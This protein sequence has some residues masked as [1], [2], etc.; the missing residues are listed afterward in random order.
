MVSLPAAQPHAPY[1]SVAIPDVPHILQEP[2]FC[3][4]ACLAMYLQKLGRR[5]AQDDVFNSSGLDPMLAR[6]CYTRDLVRAAENL[7]FRPGAIYYRIS[8]DHAAA[9]VEAQWKALHADLL[10]GIPSV[11]CMH[12]DEGPGAPEHFRLVLGY[13]AASDTVIFH[14]PAVADGSYKRMPRSTL[15]ALW[16]LSGGSQATVIRLRL[17]QDRERAGAGGPSAKGTV[18]FSSRPSEAWYPNWDSPRSGSFSAAD[19]AQHLMRLK[20]KVPAQGFTILLAPPFVVIGDESPDEVRRQT[21]GTIKWTTR[22]LKTIYFSKDPQTIIDI[23]LL[24]DDESYRK[25]CRSI[26]HN[27]PDT[28]FGFYSPSDQALIMNIAT[29]GGTLV[30]EMVHPFVATNFPHC[31]AWFN[32]GLASL[33]EKCGEKDGEIYG[34]TNWRLRG[35]QEAI[36][37]KRVPRFE[38][39]CT[40]T[41][42]EFYGHNTGVNYATARYVCYYLQEHG[43]LKKF[44]RRFHDTSKQDHSGYYALKAVLGREDMDA[45]QKEWEAYVLKLR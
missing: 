3:G 10:A 35:L 17:E 7:G 41:D 40:R 21:E 38:T 29:G 42:A 13:D 6:G 18:P 31:P 36:R 26:C 12:F 14:D 24:K 43:L 8:R 34:Y 39:L 11:V 27:T 44:Y 25:Q 45:F 32:E 15:L 23:W 2:D 33:Y 19:F 28:P 4:E 37:Q 9:D 5:V 22:Q 1:A 16:P 20:R 30:H